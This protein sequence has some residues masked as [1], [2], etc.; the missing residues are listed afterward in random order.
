M[1]IRWRLGPNE[2]I[3]SISFY[4]MS[5]SLKKPEKKLYNYLFAISLIIT[6]LCKES[7]III[8][9]GMILFKVLKDHSLS[10]DKK[11]NTKKPYSALSSNHNSCRSIYN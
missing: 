1:A 6:S 5:L 10:R 3:L 8:I 7:F 9:P 2:T 11:N 4:I